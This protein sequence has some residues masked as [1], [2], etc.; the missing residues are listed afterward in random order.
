[1]PAANGFDLFAA[2]A[3]RLN[4]GAGHFP[5]V[6][7]RRGLY[8][9]SRPINPQLHAAGISGRATSSRRA[10]FHNSSGDGSAAASVTRFTGLR[11]VLSP[12]SAGGSHPR[13]F[14]RVV[15]G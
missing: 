6:C 7:Q 1:M 5:G 3:D 8:S 2:R 13:F 9:H 15:A 14:P 12:N 10:R 4:T 11:P